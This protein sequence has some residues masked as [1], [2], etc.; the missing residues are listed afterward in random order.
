MS[1]SIS[2]PTQYFRCN[3]TKQLFTVYLKLKL[4]L[5]TLYYFFFLNFYL[6]AK[7][8]NAIL[9]KMESLMQETKKLAGEYFRVQP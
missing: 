8:G 2:M 5:G 9:R 4:K 6:L 3:N 1:F 7:S